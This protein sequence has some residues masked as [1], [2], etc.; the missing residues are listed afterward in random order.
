LIQWPSGLER[1]SS[2]DEPRYS[3]VGT[4]LA[5][6]VHKK[7]LKWLSLKSTAL[8]RD[9]ENHFDFGV[10]ENLKY[11]ELN[12][13]SV[14]KSPQRVATPMEIPPEMLLA[15]RLQVLVISFTR[16]KTPLESGEL[17]TNDFDATH[18]DWFR[19]LSQAAAAAV[20]RSP[21]LRFPLQCVQVIFKPVRAGPAV[22]MLEAEYPWDRLD[23]LAID[24][25]LAGIKLVYSAPTVSQDDFEWAKRKV[26]G[27]SEDST[28]HWNY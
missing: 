15:P 10:F 6:T 23:R 19:R 12:D 22:E 20:E 3:L 4:C 7:T 18:E 2:G 21:T 27:N 1:F 26:R 9:V 5:L 13:L 24:F 8:I 28:N 25:S 14:L 11:L 17:L 16:I